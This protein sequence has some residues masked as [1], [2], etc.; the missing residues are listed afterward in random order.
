MIAIKSNDICFSTARDGAN[1]FNLDGQKRTELPVELAATA[2]DFNIL[3]K[4]S[5][6]SRGR[7]IPGHFHLERDDEDGT[8]IPTQMSVGNQYTPIQHKEVFE[9]ITQE[10]MPQLPSMKLEMAGT[11]HGGGI[12]LIAAKFG[13]T[14]AIKGDESENELRLFF[15]NPCNGSGRMTLGFT[16]V[17]VVCQN[18]LLA[19]TEQARNDG[20]R[21]THTKSAPEVTMTAVKCIQ[22]QAVAAVEM[23]RRCKLL[24]EIGVDSETLERCLDAVY[25][26]KNLPESAA[27]T[28][29]ENFRVKVIEQFE[30]GETAQTFKEDNAWK[31]FNSFTYP[32]FNEDPVKLERSKRKDAA[33][34]AYSGMTGTVAQKVRGIFDKVE[35]VVYAA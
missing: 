35:R 23:K 27:R 34:I 6:D 15:N 32:I 12:G 1:P 9:Y 16:N 31:L 10:V 30:A 7:E 4:Q 20:W 22:A 13:D 14:F 26:I 21:I 28:R 25:P 17:R 24:A 2:F 19:A 29:L 18:T 33:E 3:K 5:Y 8:L 11:I